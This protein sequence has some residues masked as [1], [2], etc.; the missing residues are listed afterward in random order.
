MREIIIKCDH[1]G[2][3]ISDYDEICLDFYTDAVTT[4]LCDDC[5]NELISKLTTQFNEF[6]NKEDSSI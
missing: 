2:K 4:E 1:C 6:C 3:V 5:L